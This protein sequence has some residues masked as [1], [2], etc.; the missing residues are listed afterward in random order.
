MEKMRQPTTSELLGGTISD[1]LDQI[2]IR[3]GKIGMNTR[4][5][6]IEVLENLDAVAEKIKILAT[7]PSQKGVVTQYETILTKLDKEAASFLRDLGGAHVLEAL[8]REKNPP[9][10][11]YWWYLDERLTGRRKASVRRTLI[12]S[13]AVVLGVIILAAVYQFFLAPSPEVA[14]RYG[15]EQSARDGLMYGNLEDA[16]KEV[17]G[18]LSYDPTD[19]TLLILKGVILEKLGKKMKRRQSTTMRRNGYPIRKTF[20]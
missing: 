9:A 2:E 1:D 19:P 12:I 20:T 13:G 15:H 11:H 8:R 18:G 6:S 17:D 5:E 10:E 16:L 14:A 7:S 3:V 4:D